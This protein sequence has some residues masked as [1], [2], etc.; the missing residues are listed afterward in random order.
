MK[1]QHLVE[2]ESAFRRHRGLPDEALLREAKSWG[3]N[4]H[5]LAELWGVKE[6]EIREPAPP[7]ED[8]ARV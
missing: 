6:P 8:S 4:D 5:G 7:M 3:F 1:V 2:L